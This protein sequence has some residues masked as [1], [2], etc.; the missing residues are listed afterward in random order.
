MVRLPVV[1]SYHEL[2]HSSY[3]EGGRAIYL[4]TEGIMDILLNEKSGFIK[5][6]I[7]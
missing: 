3:K 5:I 7:E 6:H 2:L 1:Y 4:D